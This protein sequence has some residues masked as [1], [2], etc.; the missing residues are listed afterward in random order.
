[1]STGLVDTSQGSLGTVLEQWNQSYFAQ[2]GLHASLELSDSAMRKPKRKSKVVRRPSLT[3]SSREERERKSEDRKFVIVVAEVASGETSTYVQEL[4]T[5]DDRVEMPVPD[6]SRGFMSE[7]PGSSE[8]ET[9]EL[10]NNE[11]LAI[12]DSADVLCCV[13]ELPADVPVELPA[14]ERFPNASTDPV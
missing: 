6:D 9:S 13:A 11:D 3:Y 12:E 14:E 5:N 7:L 8:F 1:V 2:L 4:A 10:P